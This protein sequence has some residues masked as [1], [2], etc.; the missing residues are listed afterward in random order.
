MK[1]I[2]CSL[3]CKSE[4]YLSEGRMNLKT[5]L[6]TMTIT[7]HL[8]FPKWNNQ[9]YYIVSSVS[10]VSSAMQTF[11]KGKAGGPNQV[12]NKLLIAATASSTDSITKLFNRFLRE[13]KFPRL[14]KTDKSSQQIAHV[15]ASAQKED[16]HSFVITLIRFPN[17][18]GQSKL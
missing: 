16:L 7:H 6:W 14:R 4:Y 2:Q 17:K 15:Q 1:L 12:H 13:S 9:H 11:N 3:S 8:T 18:V 5:Q 10:K